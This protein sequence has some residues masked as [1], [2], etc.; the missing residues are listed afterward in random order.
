MIVAELGEVSRDMAGLYDFEIEMPDCIPEGSELV[1]I[2]NSDEP[3]SDDEIAEFFDEEG[4]EISKV[5]ESRKI[6]VS[7]WLNPERIYRPV[8]AV[9]R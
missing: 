2:S 1:Y 3:S 4:N 9:K 5:P 6:S 7:I 8:I